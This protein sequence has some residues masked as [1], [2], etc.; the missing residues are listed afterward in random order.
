MQTSAFFFSIN[1]YRTGKAKCCMLF[2]FR[3]FTQKLSS[4]R[5]ILRSIATKSSVRSSYL[6]RG[7]HYAFGDIRQFSANQ[8]TRKP[9]I[10]TSTHYI[11]LASVYVD[12]KL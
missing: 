11:L 7:I 1:I 9:I 12:T 8:F 3:E 5:F 2:L 6:L 4:I 10:R